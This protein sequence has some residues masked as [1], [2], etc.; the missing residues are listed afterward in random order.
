VNAVQNT[1]GGG[2]TDGFVTMFSSVGGEAY[3]IGYATYLGGSGTDIIYGLS[4]GSSGNARL[5]G[6]T[7]STNMP[8]TSGAYQTTNA[9]GYDAFVAEI[10][11]TP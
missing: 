3:G 7:S 11:T 10:T 2:K 5:T 6:L 9:G 4:V 8:V 1:Y